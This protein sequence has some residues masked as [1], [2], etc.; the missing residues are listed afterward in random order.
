MAFDVSGNFLCV[1]NTALKDRQGWNGVGWSIVGEEQ[2][3]SEEKT[4]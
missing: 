4:V 1:W 2:K 3:M